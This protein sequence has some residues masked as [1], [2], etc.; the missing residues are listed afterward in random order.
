MATVWTRINAL[1]LLLVLLAVVGLLAERAAG[2][3]LDPPGAPGSTDSVQLPGTPISS[4]PYTIS[5]PGHYYLTRDLS[6]SGGTAITVAQDNVSLDLGGFTLSGTGG[7]GIAYS[8]VRSDIAIEN[9]TVRGFE[10]GI[11]LSTSLRVT[12][13]NLTVIDNDSG[14]RVGAGGALSE[15][16]VR[17]NTQN[18][19]EIY[20]TSMDFGTDVRDSVISHNGLWGIVNY[21]NNVRIADNLIA[22]NYLGVF[23]DNPASWNSIIDN[24]LVGNVNGIVLWPGANVNVV[25][26]NLI[27]GSTLNILVDAGSGNRI[28]TFVGADASIT[29]TNPWSN[30]VY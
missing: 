7:N 28:G 3:P 27:L 6:F 30:V 20:Q 12:L 11:D 29:A 21:A 19:I 10:Y 9:G 22:A 13:R 26:R 16:I 8:G 2:G 4:V 17:E 25:A 1:L 5:E 15:L 18:G 24:Q 14:I 23:L